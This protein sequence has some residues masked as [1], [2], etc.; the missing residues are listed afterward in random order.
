MPEKNELQREIQSYI[1]D[2]KQRLNNPPAGYARY[3]TVEEPKKLYSYDPNYDPSLVW[4]GKTER[5]SFKVPVVSLHVHENINPYALI[6]SLKKHEG[7]IQTTLFDTSTFRARR[8]A[9]EFYKHKKN[10]SNRLIAGDSLLVM[11]S[12]LEKEGLAGK[13]QMAYVDPPYG[14]KYGSNFQPFVN[15]KDVKDGKDEDLTQEPEMIKAFR[16]TWELGIHS[17]LSYLRDRLLLIKEL[18]CD[19]G[20]VFVQISDENI[21]HVREIC[22]EIFGPTNFVTIISYS[23]TSGF[24]TNEISRAGDYIVWYAKSKKSMKYRSLFVPKE[25]GGEGG[26]LYKRI[27]LQDG[28]R[29]SISQWEKENHC[30]FSYDARPEGSRIFGLDNITSQGA[31]KELQPFEFRGKTYYPKSGNHWKAQYPEGMKR[32]AELGRIDTSDKADGN[33]NYVR[34]FEDFPYVQISN[35]W[36]DTLGQSQY[37][38]GGKKYVV[39]TS[40]Q[41]IKRCLLMSTDP[42]DLVLDITCGSGSTA[43]VAEEWG[44]RWITCDTSRISINLA[45]QRLITATYDY[46]QLRNPN[47]GISGGFIYKTVPHV[48]LKSLASNEPSPVEDLYDQP[49]V[50]KT[51]VRITGPFTIEAIPSPV[52]KP[53]DE[54]E[55]INVL[56]TRSN[57]WRDEL[58]ATGIL[59]RNRTKLNFSRIESISGTKYI[60]AIGETEETVPRRAAICFA[61]ESC[62]LDSRITSEA[63]KEVETLHPVPQLMI[64]CAFQFDPEAAKDIDEANWPGM[65]ILKVQMNTDLLTEDLKKNRASN[66]SFWLVGQPDVYHR[67]IT[68]GPDAGKYQVVI[69]GYDYYDLK[70][71]VVESGGTDKVAMWMLDTNYD[72][73]IMNPVQIY[74]PL[75]GSTGGWTKLKKTLKTE[76]DP[77]LIDEYKGSESIPFKLSESTKVAVKII[78]NRGIESMKVWTIEVD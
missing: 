44:R 19:S 59:A 66:Q 61:G 64:F 75:D 17:Y 33:I 29:L 9:L 55:K 20:S 22:D 78:D 70:E 8:E 16:D 13:V 27:E 34:Y 21:H 40:L 74:F 32:L 6:R 2:D 14:I 51:K 53:F 60:Q 57:D 24:A 35:L 4:A 25:F 63:M 10:W 11:N 3:D 23:S 42:G 7:M 41:V 77:E 69:R 67:K 76:I 54:L 39:Q 62:P 28:T 43:Y 68:T 12:L 26:T 36:K 45:K 56:S 50:D 52:V 31:G 5:T 46:Y 38:D 18:L 47:I 72:G 73:L 49:L 1:H 15:K 71:G 30:V 58:L 48:K 65:D 37:G